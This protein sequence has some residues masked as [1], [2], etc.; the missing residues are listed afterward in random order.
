MITFVVVI[1]ENHI[2]YYIT[3]KKTRCMATGSLS[4][5]LLFSLVF[6]E[7]HRTLRSGFSHTV[8]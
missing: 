6:Q 1:M 7:L 8:A 5:Y 2:E 3:R 4:G